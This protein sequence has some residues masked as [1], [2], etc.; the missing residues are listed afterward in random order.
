MA[1][2]FGFGPMGINTGLQ[3]QDQSPEAKRKLFDTLS[4]QHKVPANVLMALTEDGKTDPGLAASKISEAVASGKRVEDVVGPQVM[5]RAYDIADELYPVQKA[6]AA[7]ASTA[8]KIGDA[9]VAIA[10]GVL[11]DGVVSAVRGAGELAAAAVN[12]VG[13]PINAAIQGLTG[14]NPELRASNPLTGATDWASEKI[15]GAGDYLTSEA[16]KQDIANSQ[17]TGDITD[18]SSIS[19]GDDPS[20]NGVAQ[21]VV[22]TFGSLVPAALAAWLS[23]GSTLAVGTLGMAGAAGDQAKASDEA[24]D[25]M[26]KTVLP[27]GRTQ[28]EAESEV[29]R[30]NRAKGLSHEEAVAATKSEAA[31]LAAVMSAPVGMIGGGIEAKLFNPASKLLSKAGTAQRIGGR[32]ALGAA[33]EG[34]QEAAEVMAGRAGSNIGAGTN[35]SLTENTAADFI[36][37][38]LGGGAMA[39]GAAA[40][41]LQENDPRPQPQPE[42]LALPAPNNGGTIIPEAPQKQ[43][44][45]GDGSAGGQG[46]APGGEAFPGPNLGAAPARPAPPAGP[47]SRVAAAG[48]DLTPVPEAPPPAALFPD[49][50]PGNAVQLLDPETGV[51][52][53]AAFLGETQD[54]VSVRINGT[55]ILLTPEEFDQARNGAAKVEAEAKAAPKK[56]PAKATAPAQ[57]KAPVAGQGGQS[58]V[59]YDGLSGASGAG[60]DGNGDAGARQAD[61]QVPQGQAGAN[62]EGQQPAFTSPAQGSPSATGP[63]ELSPA[64]TKPA[65]A[66]RPSAAPMAAPSELVQ[67]DMLGGEAKTEV[68]LAAKERTKR[69]WGKFLGMAEGAK[70]ANETELDGRTVLIRPGKVVIRARVDGASDMDFRLDTEGMTR[71]QIAS[72]TRGAL[73]ELDRRAP[74]QR[75]T[76]D[77]KP[78][79]A[80][81]PE[82]QPIPG[83][84]PADDVSADPAKPLPDMPPGMEAAPVSQVSQPA[85]TATNPTLKPIRDKAMVLLGV[86]KDQ[87]PSVGK[88][89]FK[90]D[91]AE[92]GFIFS[93]KQEGAVRAALGLDEKAGKEP[94]PQLEANPSTGSAEPTPQSV[95]TS[96]EVAAA[97][98]ETDPNPTPAQTEAENY[99]TGK[100]QWNGLTLSIEN[101]KGSTRRKVTPDGKTA[102]EVK[103]PAHYGRILRTEG[104]DGDHV[105]FYMGPAPDAAEV[106][107]IDQVDA[108]TRA[109]DEHKIMLGFRNRKAALDTYAL[110]FSDGKGKDRLGAHKIMTVADFLEWVKSGDHTK[111]VRLEQKAEAPR[112]EGAPK[113]AAPAPAPVA[114]PAATTTQ[115][116]PAP[117][118]PKLTMKV[119]R[120]MSAE[121]I[122]ALGRKA[123]RAASTDIQRVADRILTADYFSIGNVIQSYSG[124]ADRVIN[125]EP[126]TD[127]SFLVTVEE[128]AIEDDTFRPKTGREARIRQHGTQPDSNALWKGPMLRPEAKPLP[129]PEAGAEP[130]TS[131]AAQP[132]KTVEFRGVQAT[133]AQLLGF[134]EQRTEMI[135][136]WSKS[137]DGA[138]ADGRASLQAKIDSASEGINQAQDL[139]A[140]HFGDTTDRFNAAKRRAPGRANAKADQPAA[141]DYGATNTF[142]TKDAAD[143]A[144]A[145]LRDKFKNQLN[146]GIDPDVLA[147]GVQLAA[148]HIEAGA[149]RFGQMAKAVADDLGMTTAQLRP[150]LRGWYNGARDTMQ[151]S[152]MDISGMDSPSAVAEE[153]GAMQEAE[154]DQPKVE[155]ADGKVREIRLTSEQVGK[156]SADAKTF[157]YKGNGDENGVNDYLKGVAEWDAVSAMGGMVY[158]YAD[159]RMVIADGHQRLGLAKRLQADGKLT[160]WTVAV[161]REVDGFTPV[162][163]RRIAA[164]KNMRSGSG[165]AIDAAKVLRDTPS[166]GDILSLPPSALVRDARA[167]AKLSPDAFGMVVN[168]VATVAYGAAVGANVAKKSAHADI[169]GLL[170]KLKPANRTQADLIA[171]QAAAETTSEVQTSLFGD[172]EVSQN[173]YLER[174]KVLDA[175]LSRIRQDR[176]TFRV[177]ADRAG[178]IA[179]EGNVLNQEANARRVENDAK[180]QAYLTAEANRKGPISEA[181]TAA[182][183]SLKAEPKR[184][185]SI[186]GSFLDAV[187]A[188]PEP[189][190]GG[191]QR[192]VG[193]GSGPGS[194]DEVGSQAGLTDQPDL[195]QGPGL[196]DESPQQFPTTLE[197]IAPKGRLTHIYAEYG[198]KRFYL[199]SVPGNSDGAVSEW[200]KTYPGASVFTTDRADGTSIN[201]DIAEL[202]QAIAAG[203]DAEWWG[204]ASRENDGKEAR[205]LLEK[206][207]LGFGR[208]GRPWRDI[209]PDE[210][211]Q[212]LA[213]RSATQGN[214]AQTFEP[215]AEGLPQAV[216][217]GAEQSE[218]QRQAA[219]TDRQRLEMEARQKQS[220]L[221]RGG[222]ERVEDDAGGLFGGAQGGLFGDELPRALEGSQPQAAS[223]PAQPLAA[224]G[225]KQPD[226]TNRWVRAFDKDEATGESIL[227]NVSEHANGYTVT[228]TDRRNMGQVGSIPSRLLANSVPL[229]KAIAAISDYLAEKNSKEKLPSISAEAKPDVRRVEPPS[230]PSKITDF[231]EKIGG[232]RKDTALPTGSRGSSAKEKDSRPGWMK[233]YE[234]NQIVKSMRPEEQGKWAVTDAKT[235]KH[236]KGEGYRAMLFDTQAEAESMIPA[237]EVARNH[238]VYEDRAQKGEFG[239]YRLVSDR[240]RPLVKGGFASY[241]EAMEYIAKNPV[242]IIEFKTRL[243]DSIHPALEEALRVGKD[244]R[245]EGRDATPQDFMETFGF[246]GVEFG[247]WNNAAERQHILN[248]AFDALLDMAEVLNLPPKAISLNGDLAL[249]FGSRGSGLSGARAH[250]ERNYGA[251]NLTKIKGAGSLAHEW[252]HAVDHYLGRQDGKAKSKKI[253][254]E[255]GDLVFDAKERKDDYAV[256]GFKFKDSGV[257]P[258]V[259]DAVKK[260]AEVMTK[261]RAEFT[262]DVSSREKAAERSIKDLADKL[263]RFRQQMATAQSYGAKK[264]PA[265]GRQLERIDAAIARI[266]AKDY[267]ATVNA[268]TKAS[269]SS[270]SFIE[271]V[272][273]LAAIYKEVRG[274]QAYGTMQGRK[275]GIAV[276]IQNAVKTRDE[277]EQ[278]L[279]DASEQRTKEKTVRSEYYSQAWAMDQGSSKDYWSTP[280]EL[281]ARAFESYVYDRIKQ[282][283]DRNDFLAYEVHNDLPAY[284]LFGIKP[285]PE[286]KERETINSAF[287]DLF[288]AIQTRETDRGV[289]M[290]SRFDLPPV[291]DLTGKELGLWEDIR[292]LGRKASAWYRANL[293]GK[294][295]TN[296]Q[297][298]MTIKFT[299]AGAKKLSGRKGDVLYRSVPALREILEKGT[300]IQTVKETKGREHI[301]AW[302]VFGAR[303]MLDGRPRD[304][305]AHV[306]E[307]RDG[308]LHY[309][310]SRD[311]SD[312]ARFMRD[313]A[314]TSI[315]A[316]RYGLEDNPVDVNLDFAEDESKA[317][318]V[319]VGAL[320]SLAFEVQSEVARH[321][322]AGKVT[323]RVVRGLLGASGVPIQGRQAGNVIE[324][325]PAAADPIGVAR[326]EII[327]ALRDPKLWDEPFGLFTRAEWLGLVKEAQADA[328]LTA[329]IG[330]MYRDKSADVQAEEA[331]AETY[332]L[333]AQGR[334]MAGPVMRAFAK[335]KAY[336]QAVANALRGQGF[337]SAALTM[338]RIARGEIGGRGPGGG[339]GVQPGAESRATDTRMSESRFDLTSAKAKA[340]GVI[341]SRHW[342]NPGEF[343]SNLV[344]DAMAGRGDGKYSALALVPGRPLFA[345][346]GKRFI[347]AKAYLRGKE[348]MDALRNDWHSRSDEVA[349]KWMALRNKMPEANTEMMDLMHRTTLSG[350]DPSRPDTWR[351]AM[352]APAQA[353][354]A[355]FGPDA[356]EWAFKVMEQIDQ[357]KQS[358]AKLRAEF[359]ALPAEF[360]ALYPEVRDNYKKMND[361]FEKAVLENIANA[362]RISLKSSER[363]HRKEMERIRDEG[364]EGEEREDAIA[365]ADAR[366]DNVKKRGG[367]GAKTQI[368]VLRKLFESNKLKGPYFPLARF[369]VYFVTIRDDK[370]ARVS[371]T[372]FEKVGQQQA[373]IRELKEAGETRIDFGRIDDSAKMREQVNPAFVA[374]IENLMA[375]SGASNEVL[376]ALWQRYLETLPDQSI[377]TAK[378]HRK[379]RAGY[380]NDAL[381][382][383]GSHMFHGAHQLAR[384]KY[385]LVL[386]EHLNDAE[387]EARLSDDPN[388]AG[389]IVSEMKKR[390]D[391][392]MNPKGSSVVA[393]MSGLAF[394]WYL[395]AT[396][397]AALANI[398]QTT[399]VGV[400]ILSAR[401]NKAGVSG[402]ARALMDATKDFAAGRG[403]KITD[404]WTV[405][406]S[407]K[408][409]SDELKAMAEAHRRGIIDRTQA[410]DL[411]AVAE[412]GIEYNPVR[413]KWMRR[414]SLFF[415]HAERFNREVT[416]LAAYRLA[417]AEGLDSADAV[418]TAADMTYKTHFDMQNTSRPRFMQNDIGKI[419]TTFRAFTVNMLW[420]LFR[421]SHQA[422]NG[423]TKEERR[424]ARAQLVGI[425]LSLMAHAG[426]RGTWGY[427]LIMLLLGTVSKLAGGGDDDDIEEWLQD[428]LLMEGDNPG[429]A[430]WNYA[431]GAALNGV[432]GQVM[433]VDLTDRIGMPNLWFRGQSRDMEAG[434]AFQAYVMDTLG[435]TLAVFA[436]FARGMEIASDGEWWRGTEAAFP[437]VIRDAMKSARYLGEGAQ[438][439]NGE[440]LVESVN[441]YQALMQGIGFTPA[442]IS[443]RYDINTRLKNHEKRIMDRRSGLQKEA[444]ASLTAGQGLD[445]GLLEQIK[446]FNRE[447]PEYP[448][449]ADTIRQSAQS[450]ARAKDR[451]EFGVS[452]NP[453]LNDRLRADRAPAIYN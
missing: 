380:S 114:A 135:R 223:E 257:R 349:Q 90:W 305:V 147:A 265:S 280:H 171:E 215:G 93:R 226:G 250:Y 20:V 22:R 158:Q 424:E 249:G 91:E 8:R 142:V 303:V 441:P 176:A 393:A 122:R 433:G 201:G 278:L 276:E 405:E 292:Q 254:N 31:Q 115:A 239:I 49:Q 444:A 166:D 446:A 211:A 154:V 375:E 284:R 38:A 207:G 210:Q 241:K 345:E 212:I 302:H 151:D 227:V 189:D 70:G 237:I 439:L 367:F 410:H 342:K 35:Q 45:P 287:A 361:D 370:G 408:L 32:A 247:E 360:Q 323:P 399:V 181:L 352:E 272:M 157:Q 41:G 378:I 344:T 264:E 191:D 15:Q 214:T 138:S 452:L 354:I 29:Y 219:M 185:S 333:W 291:A 256:Y 43:N 194:P 156:L 389:F 353:E 263:D 24:L 1:N 275:T 33:S 236:V 327:H 58:A 77:S 414:I 39:G 4:V 356:K 69:E 301:K 258:E 281:I 48:P 140:D 57:P 170:V 66:P 266:K 394:V 401:F 71:D 218:S 6:P 308:N 398:S 21:Q 427:G 309:D 108:E 244:R 434:D 319:P 134:I 132:E 9:G 153:I 152:G 121:E 438:T 449:T 371:F 430:M 435:P 161:Y 202:D 27:D 372:R 206:A 366:L 162:E 59:P 10:Q 252:W 190:L 213:A 204:R 196:F 413:E 145:L 425:T 420:R 89:S 106:Y 94:T 50:K 14:T 150:Y 251:I 351:H 183:R 337:Q 369:G 26:A 86:P 445:P 73:Q 231:G 384:L 294:T 96:A 130:P 450:T 313:G 224:L 312:G 13:Q 169:L 330:R 92:G 23:G 137:L 350:I 83:A 56:A 382:A 282:A 334:D 37:G 304:L 314:E 392:A 46:A 397:A 391:F 310:L 311:M 418:H 11:D 377:R 109:F 198:G 428:A 374:E 362:T 228:A 97:A 260:I 320:K 324:V 318:A 18:P 193:D 288:S 16:T 277:A 242:E 293:I 415:H 255:A 261:R 12:A 60:A 395:G 357:H 274:R 19:F 146:A 332:R 431:M 233:R 65:P 329:R 297:T 149:R 168:E 432:P 316:N 167:L 296:A 273:D 451:Q 325:N 95:P 216:I 419:L 174:A 368:Q 268:P 186:V 141:P 407:P 118:V 221:R 113:A 208:I 144:R 406:N 67:P 429:V 197:Q 64:L 442:E 62:P 98:A 17:I 104:A 355:R 28:I 269:Y 346:L 80:R 402:V 426:I 248:Q 326:H 436:G 102:W 173:L 76:E 411:A 99:K 365:K 403:Q 61:P 188:P 443:E 225:F 373:F 54:G 338:D 2:M 238:R 136:A 220:A 103:M 110:G 75:K 205:D 44:T 262:E 364:M 253:T 203:A 270:F 182:A 306:M 448:I 289:E 72:A 160:P 341:G 379:G 440:S 82:A 437:K 209:R 404:T 217:P 234:V 79:A 400:P 184:I 447:F 126:R 245:D 87:P 347:A 340:M 290:Y 133:K 120:A 259:R 68:D 177:L 128:G 321:G 51:I 339:G 417:R 159:G 47:I 63:A 117:A 386:E 271:P 148:F 240:K 180:V 423:A 267:G 52:H 315:A 286:G 100:I 358:Y 81:V 422:L 163:V 336:L 283:G 409:T 453:K 7:T 295:A 107:V 5:N 172:E 222:Q 232:A 78:A 285:Y 74:I 322:L 25:A 192:P 195:D 359:T 36:L 42:R 235:G 229:D 343:I 40:M 131:G 381:R 143:K 317:E 300:L 34:P 396:P 421:D 328:D 416:F 55:P 105:D 112:V 119:V 125:F 88:V 299:A 155:M 164:L 53:D 175:A 187:K 124:G 348:E 111:P 230:A 243:D 335:V 383:F 123:I 298:G 85:T 127:G 200:K 390:H 129:D 139:Y 3:P 30:E 165:T 279:A 101:A 388:R 412:T 178:T 363:A 84:T 116:V 385:G 387:E 376:D 307:T 331:V 246:R 179:E 199:A